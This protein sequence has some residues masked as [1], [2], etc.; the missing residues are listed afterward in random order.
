MKKFLVLYM[1]NAEAMEE[2]MKNSTP[3]QREAGMQEW[4][5]WMT[6]HTSDLADMGGGLGKNMR[7]TKDGSSMEKNTIGGYSII[8][9][10]SQEAAA[11]ILADNPTFKD[12]PSSY[13][14]VMEVKNM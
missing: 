12:M 5:S 8:Q 1:M 10:E 2:M 3:E 6:A 7:V 14:E 9:A 13:I 11:Q 4:K